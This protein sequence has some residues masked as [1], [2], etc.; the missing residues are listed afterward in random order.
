[1]P[2]MKTLKLDPGKY[3]VEIRNTTFPAHV[4]NLELKTRDEITV[5]HRFQ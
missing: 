5:R 3:K 1:V 4:E 2:P